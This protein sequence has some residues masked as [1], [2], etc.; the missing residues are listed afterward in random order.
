MR[1]FLGL[2]LLTAFAA[3]SLL[4]VSAGQALANHVKCGDV[5]TQDTT[6]DS[7][8][9]CWGDELVIGADNVTLDLNGHAYMTSTRVQ[10]VSRQDV[11]LENGVVRGVLLAD[12]DHNVL[13]NLAVG[14]DVE[15]QSPL[16]LSSHSE[17]NR[18]ENIFVSSGYSPAISII[19]SERNEIENSVV[20]NERAFYPSGILLSRANRNLIARNDVKA[21]QFAIG[22]RDSRGN[23]VED[24][25]VSAQYSAITLSGS[26]HNAIERNYVQAGDH[27]CGGICLE[28]SDHNLI[29]DNSGSCV[30]LRDSSHNRLRGDC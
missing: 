13:R 14:S 9:T 18:L 21:F 20:H 24:N 6:L 8:L 16:I 3:A 26:D 30:G 22:L 12:A 4:A 2:I 29:A 5:I 17:R 19:D 11:T 1:R 10:I 23:R 15:N 28:H 27:L 25:R 7:N